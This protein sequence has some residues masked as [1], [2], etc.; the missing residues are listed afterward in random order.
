MAKTQVSV[1]LDDEIIV[2]LD[3]LAAE[4]KRSRSNL[5]EAMLVG[6]FQARQSLNMQFPGRF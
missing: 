4:Q 5:I 1:S 6:F 2:E 3:K